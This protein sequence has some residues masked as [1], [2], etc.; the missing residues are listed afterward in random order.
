[1]SDIIIHIE[2]T[3]EEIYE[4]YSLLIQTNQTNDPDI[5]WYTNNVRNKLELNR[6]VFNPND[7]I[8]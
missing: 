5:E 4:I 8:H 1:M 3:N 7:V 6:N 2:P